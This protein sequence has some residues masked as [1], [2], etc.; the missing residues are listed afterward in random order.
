VRGFEE[1]LREL[2]DSGDERLVAEAVRAASKSEV[3][4]RLAEPTLVRF[5]RSG[6]DR[7][8]RLDAIE[9]LGGGQSNKSLE[10]LHELAE[11][12]DEEVAEVAQEALVMRGVLSD[13]DDLDD[14]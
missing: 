4:A 2:F 13:L 14:F 12:D 5:A 10:L 3:I 8:L 7:D 1:V 6:K 11:S 9:A